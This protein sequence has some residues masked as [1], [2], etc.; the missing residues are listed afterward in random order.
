MTDEL[1]QFYRDYL[2]WVERGAPESRDFN[3]G[4]GLCDNLSSWACARFNINTA[5]DLDSEQERM[6]SRAGLSASYPFNNELSYGREH[7]KT[8]N[9]KRIAWVREHAA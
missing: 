4:T 5:V 1:K 6:F 8:K 3:A 9:P 7:D 2:T